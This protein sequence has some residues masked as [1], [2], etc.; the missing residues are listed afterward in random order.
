M[1]TDSEIECF[2]SDLKMKVSIFG[3]IV[4][5][6][7]S[8]NSQTLLNLELSFAERTKI[9]EELTPVDY[10][11]GPES[12]TLNKLGDLWIFKK[13]VKGKEVYIKLMLGLMNR[14]AFCISFHT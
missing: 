4:R 8:K 10:H 5:D 1:T 13:K 9:I 2:L 11:Q 3:L 6:D 12:D 14:P 7:R